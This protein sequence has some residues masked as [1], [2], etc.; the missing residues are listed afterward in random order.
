M[1][2]FA[3]TLE[4]VE[5]LSPHPNADRLEIAK[6]ENKGYTLIVPKD[7]Y[8]VGDFVFLFPVDSIIPDNVLEKIGLLGKLPGNRVRT[9][10]IR[11]LISQGVIASPTE[12]GEHP[13]LEWLANTNFTEHF[14]VTRYVEPTPVD[15]TLS[16]L[17]Y[18]VKP[19]DIES[20]QK[21]QY[22][23]DLLRTEKVTI[24]EKLEGSNWGIT[25]DGN[26]HTVFQ[27]NYAVQDTHVWAQTAKELDF[28]D[29]V[30]EIYEEVGETVTLRGEIVGPKVQGNY[31]EL[32]TRKVFL[33]DMEVNGNPLDTTSFFSFVHQY[34]LP[35]VPVLLDN[36]TMPFPTPED[37]IAYTDNNMSKLNSS[38]LAEGIVVKLRDGG[39]DERVGR[40]ILKIRSP[41]YLVETKQ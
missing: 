4:A 35:C 9:V 19:Y 1:S 36:L 21:H 39:W 10:K 34:E 16:P 6:L 40:V 20:L 33:F 11:G 25:Y 26:S 15:N 12:L 18:W 5:S 28:Y 7:K 37:L 8:K 30:K 13:T 17:P 24:T 32:D 2:S 41:R 29:I 38:K 31:Y 3:V 14:G 23:W 27:R 22:L